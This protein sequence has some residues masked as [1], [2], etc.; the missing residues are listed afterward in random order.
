MAWPIGLRLFLDDW[1]VTAT[2]AF[3]RSID[4]DAKYDSTH[5]TQGVRAAGLG[6][7]TRIG[8][9]AHADGATEGACEMALVEETQF[10][11][12]V[13]Y[14]AF[15][16]LEQASGALDAHAQQERHRAASGALA[17]APGEMEAAHAG[18]A[19]Q[20]FQADAF[21]DMGEHVVADAGHG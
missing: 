9:R 8:T 5:G 17:E 13:R 4:F 19:R 7:R 16:L 12:D 10:G 15:A 1:N 6:A 11:R 18:H 3:A 2:V 20:G 14:L 21:A